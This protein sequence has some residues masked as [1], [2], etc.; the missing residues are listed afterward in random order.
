MGTLLT[1]CVQLIIDRN[2]PNR[3]KIKKENHTI[4][5]N[6][7]LAAIKAIISTVYEQFGSGC[8]L[9]LVLLMKWDDNIDYV[10]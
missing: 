5:I 4:E 9:G 6:N 3:H 8:D 10:M 1:N 2:R 7:A